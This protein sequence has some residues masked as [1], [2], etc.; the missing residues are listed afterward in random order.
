MLIVG[1][2]IAGMGSSGVMNG[3]FVV[4]AG[5]APPS[6]RACERSFPLSYLVPEPLMPFD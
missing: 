2:A 1:R 4:I 6:K 3:T 5:S